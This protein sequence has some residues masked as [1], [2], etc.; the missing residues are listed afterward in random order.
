VDE[1]EDMD[2]IQLA[3]DRVHLQGNESLRFHKRWGVF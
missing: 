2:W 3:K 1:Y